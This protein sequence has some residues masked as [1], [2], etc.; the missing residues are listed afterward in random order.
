MNTI[1]IQKIDL[2]YEAYRLKDERREKELLSSIAERG[3]EESLFGIESENRFV[4][5]DGF[6]RLRCASVLKILSVPVRSHRGGECDGV[7]QFLKGTQKKNLTFFEEASLI[8]LLRNEHK[9]S[10]AE[11]AT[12][13]GKSSGWVSIRFGVL[14]EMPVSIRDAILSGKF[15][16]R[17]YLYTLRRF[18]RVKGVSKNDAEEFVQSVSGKNL[19]L[20]SIE[21]LAGGYFGNKGF[22]EEVH[23]G[24][25]D[26]VL[27][28][29]KEKPCSS[30]QEFNSIEVRVLEELQ[31]ADALV[32]RLCFDLKDKRLQSGAFYIQAMIWVE[33]LFKNIQPFLEIMKGFYDQRR[34]KAGD[35][36]SLS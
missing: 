23:S 6:K 21:M 15:P 19:S 2:K 24:N 3:I 8:D 32:R 1:E 25:V 31:R 36:S 7:I 11:I 14:S 34:T 22:R 17:A 33:N 18:T 10:L 5:L 26:W 4:L 9:L 20:R 16:Y 28:Q 30:S 27:R 35:P 12:Q 29:L 13:L